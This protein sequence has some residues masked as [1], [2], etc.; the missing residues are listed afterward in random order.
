MKPV[1][2]KIDPNNR[3][4]HVDSILE[5]LESNGYHIHER[6]DR[7]EYYSEDEYGIVGTEYGVILPGKNVISFDCFAAEEI[8]IIPTKDQP[9][10]PQSGEK[11]E[12][13]IND[14]FDYVEGTFI[15][16]HDDMYVAKTARHGYLAWR[17]AR[18]YSAIQQEIDQ[19]EARM[20]E[21]KAKL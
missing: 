4:A 7:S 5:Y 15:G 14:D 21:L 6:V 12:V 8:F 11:I 10:T 16:M 18:P 1:K 2:I 13:R 3:K 9:W 17:Q 19:L 20:A